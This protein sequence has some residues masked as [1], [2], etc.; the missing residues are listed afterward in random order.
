MCRT[1]FDFSPDYWGQA[2]FDTS[3][4]KA[5]GACRGGQTQIELGA[6]CR[7]TWQFGPRLP[8]TPAS[9]QIAEQVR[10]S[11]A[12]P[13]LP[14]SITARQHAGAPVTWNLSTSAPLLFPR[15]H[16][17][18]GPRRTGATASQA[19][20]VGAA[21]LNKLRFTARFTWARPH[22]FHCASS[23]GAAAG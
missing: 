3:V 16:R 19:P 21:E 1:G 12:G 17:S 5:A 14:A 9:G 23:T 11:S 8:A 6:G 10:H 20:H 18:G 4:D 13:G 7:R 22:A 2:C 15:L